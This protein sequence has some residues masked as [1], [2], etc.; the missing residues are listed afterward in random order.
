MTRQYTVGIRWFFKRL[1]GRSFQDKIFDM[2]AQLAYYLLLAL[3]PFLILMFSLLSF[4]P[5]STQSVLNLVRPFAPQGSMQLIEKNLYH[6]LEVT[7]G[8]LLSISMVI[9]IWLSVMG[10]SALIRTLNS[11]YRVEESRALIHSL[12]VA[13]ALTMG[14]I[15][16][17]II[18]LLLSVFGRSIGLFVFSHLG[19]STSFLP[20]DILRWSVSFI[21]LLVVFAFLYV[22]AP[23]EK[24]QLKDII[25]GALFAT[26]GWQLASL[27]FSYY[28]GF[29][30]YSIIY[31]NL[32]TIVILMIW[33]YLSSLMILI[34]GEINAIIREANVIKTVK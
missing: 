20:W 23:N 31:G 11:A 5:V 26:I 28:V 10:T 2:A 3:F 14:M 13:V 18:S 34:G 12:C 27:G 8:D 33:F 22:I 30:N 4:L 25:P 9:T 7:R 16:G 1:I 17:V 29:S 24:L 19:I 32:G 6:V 15:T 21:I